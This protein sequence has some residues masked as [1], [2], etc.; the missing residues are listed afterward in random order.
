MSRKKKYELPSG[1]LRKQ[2]YSHSEPVHD[3]D[4]K[5]VLLENGKQKMKRIYVSIT[6][7]TKTELNL[8]VAEYKTNQKKRGNHAIRETISFKNARENYISSKSNI[9]SASTIRG[10]KQMS[11][12]YSLIDDIDIYKLTNTD[13]QEWANE[14]AKTHSPKTVKNAHGLISAVLQ[15]YN[16]DISLHTTLP[17]KVKPDLYVPT[18]NDVQRL[19]EYFESRDDIDMQIAV[20][21]ASCATMRRSEICGLQAEDIKGNVI[22]VHQAAVLN[23]RKDIVL[24]TTKTVSSDRYID[25]PQYIVD[26]LPTKGPVVN[27]SPDVITHRFKHAINHLGLHPFRFH[28]LRHYAASVMHAIGIPDQYIMERGGWSS[29]EVLKRIYRGTMSDYRRKFIEQTNRHFE[30]C[31]TKC[32]TN[33]KSP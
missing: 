6:A 32:N 1:S 19:I 10:Y 9:L 14:F 22:H 18:E 27:I 12:Y 4:G 20:H 2:V 23:D 30:K 17:Q 29:D 33:L 31:N 21:L 15:N 8:K 25:G 11:T 3:S 7:S 26:L 5:P 28:D 16:C 24:K 13:I